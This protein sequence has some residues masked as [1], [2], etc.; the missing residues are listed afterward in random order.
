V[1]AAAVLTDAAYV[2]EDILCGGGG[3]LLCAQTVLAIESIHQH[4]YIH[5]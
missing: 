5:R 3:A 1:A 2:R 4:N